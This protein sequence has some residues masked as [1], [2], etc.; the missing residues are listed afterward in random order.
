MASSRRVPTG[1]PAGAASRIAWPVRVVIVLCVLIIAGALLVAWWQ[2]PD[3]ERAA[4]TTSGSDLTCGQSPCRVL[5]SATVGGRKV[6]LLTGS[7]SRV[8]RLRIDTAT[9]EQLVTVAL[10]ELSA[11]N[12]L[13]C[14]AGTTPACLVLGPRDR[15]SVGEV[16]LPR[17]Q[18]W[19]APAG[20]YFSNAG[21][22]RLADV[23]GNDSPEVVVVEHDCGPDSA[24][25]VCREVPV[26]GKVYHLDGHIAGCTQHYGA[27]ARIPGWSRIDLSDAALRPCG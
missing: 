8:G 15:G 12:P 26:Q 22:I 17:G 21:V 3:A 13:R 19:V 5:D 10:S 14:A 4:S 6:A 11:R 2:R 27:P 18:E 7:S 20:L 25:A 1:E 24:P 16:F 9:G 23:L